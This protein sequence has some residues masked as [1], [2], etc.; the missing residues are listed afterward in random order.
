MCVCVF[1]F[2]DPMFLR[3][4]YHRITTM[5]AA[6]SWLFHVQWQSVNVDD[7][8]RIIFCIRIISYL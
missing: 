8:F 4:W 1:A 6:V 7:P 5:G 3:A 2:L